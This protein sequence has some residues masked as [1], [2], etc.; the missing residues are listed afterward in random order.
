MNKIE[1]LV[2][3]IIIFLALIGTAFRESILF[4]FIFILGVIYSI[5]NGT[6][7]KKPGIPIAIFGG[8]LITRIATSEFFI[9]IFKSETVFD[10]I[11]AL[12]IFLIV[13]LIGHQIKQGGP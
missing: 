3:G 4:G 2:I 6:M 8:G 10:L 1:N 13:F 5:Y 12:F 9:P 7:E 11:I